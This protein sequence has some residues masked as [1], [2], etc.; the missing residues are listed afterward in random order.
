MP[1]TISGRKKPADFIESATRRSTIIHIG[2][3][4]GG[5]EFLISFFSA[6]RPSRTEKNPSKNLQELLIVI[7]KHPILLSNLHNALIS[8]LVQTDLSSALTE[9]GIPLANGFWPEFFR[10]LRHKLIPAFRN[11]N[12][13]L[14]VIGRIFYR[15]DD[16]KWV[17]AIP[18]DQWKQFF[19]SIGLAFS[20]DDKHILLQ[21]MQSLK[22]LSVQIASLGLEKEVRKYLLA[23]S[24]DENP[25]LVQADLIRKIE[26]SFITGDEEELTAA[27]EKLT[28]LISR[29]MGSIEL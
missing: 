11:E 9:S 6:I 2:D 8:Q 21:L 22:I 10:R 20:V 28:A 5:L 14:D 16:Y 7:D 15:S 23:K 12:D 13:F 17:E 29:G 4:T 24:L 19:E 3:K 18:H 1:I 27:G 26:K 25:F